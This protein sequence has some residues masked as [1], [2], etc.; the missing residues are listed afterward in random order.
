M[1]LSH[2]YSPLLAR[3]DGIA[4]HRDNGVVA[5]SAHDAATAI[6][7]L[8]ARAV[9]AE[10]A[11]AATR[12][13]LDDLTRL[14][15]QRGERIDA[16]LDIPSQPTTCVDCGHPWTRHTSTG[17]CMDLYCHCTEPCPDQ[18]NPTETT[19]R[20]HLACSFCGHWEAGARTKA[21]IAEWLRVHQAATLA[22]DRHGM[23]RKSTCPHPCGTPIA[24][25][26]DQPTPAA[27]QPEPSRPPFGVDTGTVPL[28]QAEMRY[29]APAAGQPEPCVCGAKPGETC[30][31]NC[32][33]GPGEH[34]QE[35]DR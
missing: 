7:S 11:L 15:R 33:I 8:E 9:A 18:P 10:T 2:D 27:G 31:P 20:V 19:E 29:K 12:A 17:G 4:R 26:T 3:L 6:R 16:L 21:Q 30:R 13:D 14:F 28:S 5:I 32:P 1:G 34:T 24:A 25:V 23:D 35:T 22:P